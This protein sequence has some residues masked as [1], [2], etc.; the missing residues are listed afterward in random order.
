MNA[1]LKKFLDLVMDPES[2]LD[3][4]KYVSSRRISDNDLIIT[5]GYLNGAAGITG[6][7]FDKLIKIRFNYFENSCGFYGWVDAAELSLPLTEENVR[8]FFETGQFLPGT[9]FKDKSLAAPRPEAD[10]H[11]WLWEAV[12]VDLR[13]LKHLKLI[14]DELVTEA[15]VISEEVIRTCFSLSLKERA[16]LVEF[17]VEKHREALRKHYDAEQRES[18]NA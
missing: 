14:T 13:T 8:H 9:L 1:D 10:M 15:E 3:F 11:W 5:V 7:A 17:E 16:C 6:I 18:W 4:D 12:I 2:R